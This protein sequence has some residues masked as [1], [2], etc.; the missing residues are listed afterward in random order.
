MRRVVVTGLGLV[1]PLGS[2]VP[3][4]WKNI[5]ASRSGAARSGPESTRSAR[6]AAQPAA[7]KPVPTR[8]LEEG[9]PLDWNTVVV[10]ACIPVEVWLRAPLARSSSPV[11]LSVLGCLPLIDAELAGE[12]IRHVREEL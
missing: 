8:G 4:V 6:R 11:W 5:L 10:A 12:R 9:V 3:T 7:S 2:D 1:T